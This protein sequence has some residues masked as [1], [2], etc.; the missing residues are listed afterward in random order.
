MQG[1]TPLPN[2]R[3]DNLGTPWVMDLTGFSGLQNLVADDVV[4][5]KIAAFSPASGSAVDFD[6][7][8]VSGTGVAVIPEPGTVSLLGLGALALFGFRS[9]RVAR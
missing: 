8:I 1:Q 6:N 4:T 7:I 5:F 9:R 2:A 3:P